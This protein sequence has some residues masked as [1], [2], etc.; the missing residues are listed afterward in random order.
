MGKTNRRNPYARELAKPQYRQRVVTS[1]GRKVK[2]KRRR[3]LEDA[4][5]DIEYYEG[6]VIC[7]L[8]DGCD[9]DPGK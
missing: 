2:D 8:P 7:G 1:N 9:C 5:K 6:C 3:K 4:E